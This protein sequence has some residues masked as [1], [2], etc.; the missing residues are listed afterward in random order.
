MIAVGKLLWHA[1]GTHHAA[2]PTCN[3]YPGKSLFNNLMLPV[4]G[5]VTPALAPGVPWHGG[6]PG[7]RP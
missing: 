1:C 3:A 2:L 6:G 4:A 5:R 7:A